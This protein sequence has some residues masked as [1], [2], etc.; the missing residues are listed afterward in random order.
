[1]LTDEQR[2]ALRKVG[3]AVGVPNFLELI[4]EAAEG[5]TKELEGAGVS[6]KNRKPQGFWAQFREAIRPRQ[7][8]KVAP[9]K[10]TLPKVLEG[11][12][13][14]ANANAGVQDI[15]GPMMKQA[16]AAHS[17]DLAVRVLAAM[18]ADPD[19][20]VKPSEMLARV[21]KL[22]AEQTAKLTD[23]DHRLSNIEESQGVKAMFP[24]D[25]G[26]GPHPRIRYDI[27]LSPGGN[28]HGKASEFNWDALSSLW[29]GRAQ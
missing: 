13:A 17:D 8:T 7:A 2:E 19:L 26:L 14:A 25:L 3:K 18:D 4:E 28:G 9:A 29:T 21:T 24:F 16:Q 27:D 22:V 10:P 6:Y 5:K 15:V 23:I 12:F 1:M 11:A 20:P